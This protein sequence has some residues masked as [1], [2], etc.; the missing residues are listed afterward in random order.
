MLASAT[1]SPGAF[2][3]TKTLKTSSFA[4]LMPFLCFSP[5][6]NHCPPST[7]NLLTIF[8]R[9]PTPYP[10]CQLSV[11]NQL[12][13]TPLLWRVQRQGPQTT[14]FRSPKHLATPKSA[15]FYVV[16]RLKQYVNH[17]PPITYIRNQQILV[18]NDRP[19]P[20]TQGFSRT[21]ILHHSGHKVPESGE[22]VHLAI[23]I[24]RGSSPITAVSIRGSGRWELCTGEVEAEN[25]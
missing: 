11:G 19:I 15:Q 25:G 17:C 13:C 3:P 21:L 20:P 14:H 5:P 2:D 18:V 4:P 10:R 6:A 7:Y 22:W 24:R 8:R 23:L 12:E 9:S 1:R 16:F